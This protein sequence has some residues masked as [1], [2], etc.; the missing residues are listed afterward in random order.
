MHITF[1]SKYIVFHELCKTYIFA[2]AKLY[3]LY[4]YMFLHMQKYILC[5]K[6]IV[7]HMQ[8]IQFCECIWFCT[9]HRSSG[10]IIMQHSAK[11]GAFPWTGEMMTGQN[12]FIIAWV[13]GEAKGGG[14]RFFFFLAAQRNIITGK[15]VCFILLC[16]VC[17]GSKKKKWAMSNNCMKHAL[18]SVV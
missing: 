4:K 14:L 12:T 10:N 3:V 11:W 6:H 13:W 15:W 7:L 18:A 2:Y 17:N 1:Y 5:T 16:M 8:N 9:Q